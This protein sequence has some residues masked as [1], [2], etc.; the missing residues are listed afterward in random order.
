MKTNSIKMLFAVGTAGFTTLAAATVLADD[1]PIAKTEKSCTGMITAVDPQ[2]QAV[3]V[4]S[5]WLESPRRFDLGDNCA[6]AIFDKN[7]GAFDDL[8][9][10]EKIKVTYERAYGVLIASRIEQVPMRLAGIVTEMDPDKHT[11]SVHRIGLNK[12]FAIAMDCAVRLRDGRTGTLTNIQTGSQVTVT[13]ETPAGEATARLI[14]QTSQEFTGRLT[15]IDLGERTLKAKTTFGMKVF[16]LGNHCAIVV[17]GK[18]NG[19]PSDLKLSEDLV[20][21][22]D[23]INGVNIVNRIAPAVGAKS[24]AYATGPLSASGPTPGY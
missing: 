12:S 8:R 5:W 1:A 14:T 13:Y 21:D 3:T 9:A 6:Y 17:N 15:A 23:D 7:P 19:Q 24:S 18:P 11:L 22:Y 16:H 10:G 2:E 4:K 20:F